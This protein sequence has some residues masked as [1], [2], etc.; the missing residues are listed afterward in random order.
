M[1]TSCSCSSGRRSAP[2]SI[3]SISAPAAHFPPEH[4]DLATRPSIEEHSP[5]GVPAEWELGKQLLFDSDQAR[6][7]PADL[8]GMVVLSPTELLLVNDNDFGVEGAETQFWKVIF[9]RPIL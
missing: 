5:P 4:L 9:D 8:E 3:G 7:I 2:G 1:R 6:E